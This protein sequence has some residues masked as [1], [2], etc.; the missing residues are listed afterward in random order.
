M[1]LVGFFCVL[2]ALG[3]LV[4][5]LVQ[6]EPDLVWASIGASAV[7]GVV[8]AIAS[9]QRGRAL[10]RLRAGTAR[11]EVTG[12]QQPVAKASV[13]AQPAKPPA[14]ER[15]LV[16]NPPSAKASAAKPSAEK[17]VA[18]EPVA[19]EPVAEKPEK[20]FKHSVPVVPE[21]APKSPVAAESEGVEHPD[22][23]DELQDIEAPDPPDEPAE[24]D[25]DM[26]DLLVV[27]DLT[28]EVL[29]VDLRPRYH[30]AACAHLDGREAI[31]I[32]VCEAREDGFTPCAL[33][34]PDAALA[35]AAREARAGAVDRSAPRHGP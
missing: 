7:G 25:V 28:D 8:V 23:D 35:A 20:V 5:G 34:R 19:E 27:I 26:A 32:P 18:Q 3:L 13:T 16:E 31:P 1:V 4:V 30:L 14:P 9:I 10:R 24:E 12:S 29:V 33:C 11:P 17:P 6:G 21:V 2:G 22:P 15:S